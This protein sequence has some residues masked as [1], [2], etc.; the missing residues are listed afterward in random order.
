MD[1]SRQPSGCDWVP[2]R[3]RDFQPYAVGCQLYRSS[4]CTQF[5]HAAAPSVAGSYFSD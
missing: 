3:G 5:G 2:P 4:S 1:K